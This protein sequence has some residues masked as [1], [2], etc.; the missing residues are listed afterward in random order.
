MSKRD[1]Y[2]ILGVERGANQDQIKRAFRNKARN[3]HPDNQDSGDE[4]A[5]KE[6]ALAYEVLSD[7]QKRSLY[8]RYGHDG[9]SGGAAGFEGVDL[10]AFSDLGEIFS[11]FFGGGGGG[12]SG[13]RRSTVERGADL[14][15]DL[16]LD[17]LEAVF[18]TEK[19]ITIKHMEDCTV[20]S[21]SGAAPGSG[22]VQC[23][24][25][26]GMGQI[27][28]T[29]ATFLGHFTQVLTCPN[30]NG[31][32]TRIDKA[33]INCKGRGQVRKGRDIELKVPAG[34]DAG[35]R[36]RIP[37]AGD[38][39]R[40]GGPPGDVYVIVHVLEHPTFIREGMTIHV[41]QPISFSMSALGGELMVPTV[42]GT[43]LLKVP[44]GTQSGTT[45][46]MREQG[47]PQLNNPARRGDEVVHLMVETPAKLSAEERKLLEQLAE[48][49]GESLTVSKPAA[50]PAEPNETPDAGKKSSASSKKEKV[51]SNGRDR[52]KKKKNDKDQ[53]KD[54]I[55]DKLADFFGA[56]DPGD[57]S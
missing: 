14:K 49:R 42:D 22:P 37:N 21:G 38:Q 46:V 39:G 30:C 7:E 6:L 43:R 2:E 20:C 27:R 12:R 51:A 23:T 56:K 34:I 48:L 10:S 50:G 29:T 1:Y 15:Y 26:S 13:F 5:F 55:I 53:G 52:S 45:I 32:G 4:A 9:L 25:C 33:C 11:Q 24:T 36:L 16:Q 44:A 19:K 57:Q 40:K 18:G 3:L 31:E 35:A 54:S 41:K 8:D 17:F 47:V 28:Q